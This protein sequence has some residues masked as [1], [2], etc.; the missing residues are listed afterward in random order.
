LKLS[1]FVVYDNIRLQ[2]GFT[3]FHGKSLS[4]TCTELDMW[5]IMSSSIRR[6]G[7][8]GGPDRGHWPQLD[9]L[10]KWFRDVHIVLLYWR[11][12]TVQPAPTMFITGYVYHFCAHILF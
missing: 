2:S 11:I 4:H 3:S 1:K 10:T 6:V 12:Q 9:D 8:Q 7:G 5:T